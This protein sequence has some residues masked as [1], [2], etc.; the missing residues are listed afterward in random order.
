MNTR[1]KIILYLFLILLAYVL[2]LGLLSVASVPSEFQETGAILAAFFFGMLFVTSFDQLLRDGRFGREDL[3]MEIMELKTF[4]P[5]FETVDH[6]IIA[7]DVNRTVVLANSAALEIFSI[8]ETGIVGK[9]FGA[10]L[11]IRNS[12]TK[13]PD[14]SFVDHAFQHGKAFSPEGE[15]YVISKTGREV[16]V[17]ITATPV[18]RENKKPSGVIVALHDLTAQNQLKMARKK[19]APSP[20]NMKVDNGGKTRG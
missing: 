14:I 10:H 5:V 1:K 15:M 2:F 11:E 7:V 20:K 18:Y 9:P 8:T 4:H 12:L 16:P 17:S 3:V 6:G 19:R 13:A